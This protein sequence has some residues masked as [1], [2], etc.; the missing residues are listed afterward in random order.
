MNAFHYFFDKLYPIIRFY[1][2]RVNSNPWFSPIT[3]QLWLGGSPTYPRD[4][5]QI[6]NLG[7]SGIVDIRAERQGAVEQYQ[8]HNISY[9]H[10]P[11]FD[12][13]VPSAEQIDR[14]VEFTH[15][16]ITHGGKVLIHCAKGRGRSAVLVA[17]YLM[18]YNGMSF[19]EAQQ[20]LESKRR[21]VKLESR[22][23]KSAEAWYATH[24][25]TSLD[26]N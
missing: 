12:M 17:A 19:G 15:Q 22:H 21:L 23:E 13:L 6:F 2:E 11:V 8:A 16:Q 26:Q 4:Y 5:E 24:T 18:K 1:H 7:L 3:P 10:L 20:F 9:L 14:A 25:T